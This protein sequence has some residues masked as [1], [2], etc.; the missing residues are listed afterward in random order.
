[1]AA[2][3]LRGV[4]AAAGEYQSLMELDI[5][6]GRMA[7]VVAAGL[8]PVAAAEEAGFETQN[9]AMAVVFDYEALQPVSDLY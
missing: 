2:W 9:Q 1:M 3:R 4:I 6:V 8:N 7:F 5:D